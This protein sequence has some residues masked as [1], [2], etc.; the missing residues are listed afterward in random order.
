MKNSRSPNPYDRSAIPGSILKIESDNFDPKTRKQRQLYCLAISAKRYALFLKD[1]RGTPELLRKGI[2]ND[3]DRWSEHGLG[4]LLNPTDPASENRKWIGQVW[5]NMI[6]QSLGMPL[7][8]LEFENRP[9]VGRVTVSSPAVIRPLANLNDGKAYPE[10]IK[11]FNFLLT[12]HVK[13]FGHPKGTDPDRFHLIA[14]Y[15]NNA[16]QWLKMD[17]IDQYAGN[18]Y[19]ITTSGH[20]GTRKTAHVKTYGDILREYEYHPESKCADAAGNACEKQTVGLL[21]RRHVSVDHIK[22]IGKESNHL[23][24]VDAG[25]IHREESIYTECIDKS[26]DEWQTNILPALRRLPLP[27]LIIESGLSRRALLDIRT[28]RSRPHPKNQ[29]R[30][31]AIVRNN[32]S[33]LS[34]HNG[35]YRY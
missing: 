10:Q 3:A 5:R 17:W 6:L 9:A 20:N 1:R 13:A 34:D 21:R 15:N 27:R 22:F 26:R 28:G 16:T 23:E 12:C 30:L 25:L 4:H 35:V 2:N 7:Q 8:N 32:E 19:R 33:K 29:E 31:T 11:P 14:P 18:T 24:A